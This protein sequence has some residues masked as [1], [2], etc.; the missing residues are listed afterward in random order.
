VSFWRA[1]GAL[2]LVS[3]ACVGCG[4]RARSS[5]A[6][7]QSGATLYLAGINELWKVDV[8]TEQV[9][10]FHMSQIGAGDPPHL[11][12]PIGDRLAMWNYD[13]TSV[14]MAD[15]GA[16]PTTL[17]KKGWIFIP[18]ADPDRIWVGFLD[19]E[20]PATE[21]GLGELQEI[22]STGNAVRR[23]IVPPDG[24]WPYAEVGGGLLFQGPGPIR[25][26]DPDT[27]Q[28]MRT[29]E[30]EQIG[31]MGPV[32]GNLLASDVYKSGVLR[33][34]DVTTGE[35]RHIAAP[36]G[37][38]LVAWEASFSPDGK[39]LA[40]P[41][42]TI[43]DR[44]AAQQLALLDVETGELELVPGTSVTTGYNLT[45][46]SRDGDEVFLTGG[47]PESPREIVAYRVGDERATTLDIDVDVGDFFDIA[48]D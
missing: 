27:G 20:S 30:W 24:A 40:V 9:E 48:A 32:S 11:I 15:P 8:A 14:P 22:D 29:W 21:R 23:G 47:G 46:W 26:W 5:P 28:T 18:A 17:A 7:E 36:D 45:A 19:P 16:E 43:G 3:V 4:E 35:Q 38:E 42:E 2:V 33:L 1:V 39:T 6:R 31:D 13:I 37:F 12:S 44:N 41:L 10:H 34:T 25:L